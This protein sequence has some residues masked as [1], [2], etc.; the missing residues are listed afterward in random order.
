M[1]LKIK[2]NFNTDTA[3]I[4]LCQPEETV[5]TQA[6]SRWRNASLFPALIA[7]EGDIGRAV[8]LD[9]DRSRRVAV[10]L[11]EADQKAVVLPVGVRDAGRTER[12]IGGHGASA[13]A[14]IAAFEAQA[15]ERRDVL[16]AV[17]VHA[18]AARGSDAR[19]LSRAQHGPVVVVAAPGGGEGENQKTKSRGERESDGHGTR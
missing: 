18:S 11:L 13:E 19:L 16:G 5:E 17:G 6:C 7:D 1:N 10:D 8:R 12:A 9:V 14:A 3:P 4:R 15:L 2:I